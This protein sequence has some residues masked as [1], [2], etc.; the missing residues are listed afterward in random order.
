[1]GEWDGLE[2][3]ARN[4]ALS[5]LEVLVGEWDVE[6]SNIT[7]LS[8]PAESIRIEISFAW[9]F[10][11]AFLRMHQRGGEGAIV[12]NGVSVI[13]RDAVDE[14]YTLLY[15]DERGVSRNYQMSLKGGTWKVWRSAPGFMQRFT[16]AIGKGGQRI[17]GRWERSFDEGNWEHDFDITYVRRRPDAVHGA[18]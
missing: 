5:E 9:L 15:F 17:A 16:G 4:P 10:G 8:A 7:F 14:N 13:S 1:M 12:P 3:Q 2:D 6:I 11:G 18:G